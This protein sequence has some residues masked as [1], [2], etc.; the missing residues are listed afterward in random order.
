MGGACGTYEGAER[1]KVEK[2][3]R[4]KPLDKPRR[5]WEYN[6]KLNME[7]IRW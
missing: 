2:L 3:K 1:C 7:E 5:R 4:K 6:I